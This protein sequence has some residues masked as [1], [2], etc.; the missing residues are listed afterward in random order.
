MKRL[1]R[2]IIILM[3]SFA[4]SA[5]AGPGHNHGDEGAKALTGPTSPR[6]EA[7]SDLF[8]VVGVLGTTELAVFIDRYA[9]NAPVRKAR[10]EVESGSFKAVGEFN[11]ETGDYHFPGGVFQKPGSYPVSLTI[12]AGEDIDILAANLIVPDPHVGHDHAP[13][14]PHWMWWAGGAAVFLAIAFIAFVRRRQR[15]VQYA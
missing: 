10:V 14:A 1:L 3:A 9:D 6:F 13:G 15:S 2:T 4:T 7:H 8:E 11:A 12:T 5:F